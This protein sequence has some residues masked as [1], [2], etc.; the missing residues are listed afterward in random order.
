MKPEFGNLDNIELRDK[1]EYMPKPLMPLEALRRE[2]MD[3]RWI[4]E[5]GEC[6]YAMVITPHGYRND[7]IRHL[8]EDSCGAEILLGL[9]APTSEEAQ[10]RWDKYGEAWMAALDPKNNS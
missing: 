4:P 3:T 6:F 9:A 7:G 5:V 2:C 10:A 8:S 1:I